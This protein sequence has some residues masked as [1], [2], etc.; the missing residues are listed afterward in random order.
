MTLHSQN[1]LQ[2][3]VLYQPFRSP[4]FVNQKLKKLGKLKHPVD[5]SLKVTQFF[6]PWRD[7]DQLHV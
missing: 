5:P 1:K 6:A 3:T 7:N 2:T 4:V